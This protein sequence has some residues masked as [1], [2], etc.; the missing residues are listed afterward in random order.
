[1]EAFSE[2]LTLLR[3]S[4]KI[5]NNAQFCGNWQIDEHELEQTCFHMVTVGSCIMRQPN[6][7]DITLKL[8]DLVVFPRETPHKLLAS[9]PN[10]D[11]MRIEPINTHQQG[12]GLICG[13]LIFEHIAF[14]QFLN[15]LPK[16]MVI[17]RSQAP[18]L[19]P[20]LL[21]IQFESMHQEPGSDVMLNRLSELLFT[22]ALRHFLKQDKHISFLNLYSHSGLTPA[23]KQIHNQPQTPWT[24][25]LLAVQC[26]MSRTKFAT[27][28]KKVS[29]W[30]FNEYLT[31]WRMQLAWPMLEK[32]QGLVEVANAVGYQSEAAFS[33]VFKKTFDVHAG[34]VRRGLHK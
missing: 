33:R 10:T 21:Q 25:E 26:A 1:M 13:Q 31:W 32:G 2:F 6:E 30:T 28:F 12:T 29:G 17:Q 9:Q 3:V 15:L 7:E 20:L 11:K 8:G 18:W 24:L 5:Y 14:N 4:A 27:L 22:Y 34:Q 19:E 23:I 16:V